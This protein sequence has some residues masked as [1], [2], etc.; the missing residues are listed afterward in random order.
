M[1]ALKATPL[2]KYPPSSRT[3][4]LQKES[5]NLRLSRPKLTYTNFKVFISSLVWD[6]VVWNVLHR[7]LKSVQRIEASLFLKVL[8]CKEI[9]GSFGS[10]AWQ[11]WCLYAEHFMPRRRLPGTHVG[12]PLKIVVRFTLKW[13]VCVI[14]SHLYITE[15][16]RKPRIHSQSLLRRVQKVDSLIPRCSDLAF[17]WRRDPALCLHRASC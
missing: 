9:V 8:L 1:H 6:F 17:Q 2:L 14:T 13:G 15:A 5:V 10:Q 7:V 4:D 12:I 3:W 11:S 16:L